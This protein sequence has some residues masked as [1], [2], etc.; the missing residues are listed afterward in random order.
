MKPDNKTVY[1]S[2]ELAGRY[3]REE[4]LQPPEVSILNL[5][6]T[7]LTGARMLDV[8]V[9]GGRTTIHFAPLVESYVGI[10]YSESM[11]AT[12]RERFT[13]IPNRL[14]FQVAD[15]RSLSSFP[16][17]SFDFVLFSYNGLDYIPHESRSNALLEI[18]RV[19]KRGGYFALSTHNLNSLRQRLRPQ[20]VLKPRALAS[21]LLWTYRFL[22]HNRGLYGMGKA[23][24][25]EVYDG[26]LDYTLRTHYTTPEFTVDEL[27]RSGFH[28]IR[29]FSLATGEP[30][31]APEELRANKEDWLYYL[32]A[33]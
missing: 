6:R 9:G 24:Y 33:A 31:V 15:V 23:E 32:S 14:T 20:L 7:H 13:E 11:I 16:D 30:I 1:E 19:L 27:T 25:C 2:G 3:G 28:E 21:K 18:R 5:I 17:Q 12:C 4:K 10:D 29:V 26:A 22:R 8:G